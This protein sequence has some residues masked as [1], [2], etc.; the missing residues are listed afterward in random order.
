[1]LQGPGQVRH[2]CCAEMDTSATKNK[3]QGL[4][5]FQGHYVPS[6]TI[7][8]TEAGGWPGGGFRSGKAGSCVCTKVSPDRKVTY[9]GF[10]SATPS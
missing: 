2:P 8:G 10:G 9:L 7:P 1:M 5:S 4:Y 3:P 6:G